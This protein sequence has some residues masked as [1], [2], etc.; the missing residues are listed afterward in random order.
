MP[1]LKHC[2]SLFDFSGDEIAQLLKLAHLMKADPAAYSQSLAGQS[3][4]LLFEKPSLRTRVSFE[5][6]IYQ[7]GGHAV[8]LDSAQVGPGKREPLA[9]I[10]NNLACWTQAIIARVYDHATLEGLSGGRIP[11]INALCDKSHPCQTLADLLT[12]QEHFGADLSTIEVA[13][14]GDGNNVC[15]SLMAG[16]AALNMTLNV[17]TPVECAPDP[18]FIGQLKNAYPDHRVRVLHD[19][20]ALGKQDALY[21]DTWI[22]MGDTDSAAKKALLKPYQI[23]T[24]LMAQTSASIVMHCLPAHRGEEV[25]AEV[26]DSPASVIL[27]QA[28]NRMHAQKALLHTLLNNEDAA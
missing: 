12:L 11:V 10:A 8:Y 25:T 24:P 9:D 23:N 19:I 5:V 6:G 17:V 18:V 21:T 13:Y 1:Q 27:Q 16:A 15:C 20:N 14:L 26:L 22:S 4:A 2:L 7:L 28:E 3:L